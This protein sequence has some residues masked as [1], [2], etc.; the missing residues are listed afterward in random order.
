MLLLVSAALF[1]A[2]GYVA[3]SGGD[4]RQGR[5]FGPAGDLPDPSMCSHDAHLSSHGESGGGH[6]PEGGGG[7]GGGGGSWEW[8]TGDTRY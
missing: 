2:A 4:F 6:G 1:F 5:R 7:G 8:E 3:L